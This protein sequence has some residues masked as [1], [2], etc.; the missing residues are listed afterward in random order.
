MC[1]NCYSGTGVSGSGG[2]DVDGV[3]VVAYDSLY[4]FRGVDST[5][6]LFFVS[7]RTQ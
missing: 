2:G 5:L 7:F 1:V 6:V 4:I 3:L